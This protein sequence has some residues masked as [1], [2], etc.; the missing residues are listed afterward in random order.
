MATSTSR[1]RCHSSDAR[2]EGQTL[3]GSGEEKETT[4]NQATNLNIVEADEHGMNFGCIQ[5][6]W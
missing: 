6:A 4:E 1:T 5:R 3:V 2:K